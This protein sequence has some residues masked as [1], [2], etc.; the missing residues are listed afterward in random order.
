MS[1]GAPGH[2]QL[3][4]AA[5]AAAREL[6]LAAALDVPRSAGDLAARLGADARMLARLVD[7]LACF[8]WLAREPDGRVRATGEPPANARGGRALAEMVRRGRPI[9]ARDPLSLQLDLKYLTAQRIVYDSEDAIRETCA[10]IAPFVAGGRVLDAGGGLGAYS[11]ALADLVPGTRPLVIDLASTVALARDSLGSH[12]LRL[13][14]RAGDLAEVE[15]GSGYQLV[16]VNNV[17]H[18]NSPAAAQRIL[19]RLAGALAPG[20][21]LVVKDLKIHRDRSGTATGLLFAL[22]SG[23]LGAEY[24]LDDVDSLVERVRSAGVGELDVRALASAPDAIVVIGRR[25]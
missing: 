1:D 8:G 17:L 18:M 21:H 13:D 7:V 11:L 5:L 14:W 25:A 16:L 24:S 23:F 10:L 12:A 20:G 2:A 22:A 6:E 4:A 15:L 9:D 3:R 19:E